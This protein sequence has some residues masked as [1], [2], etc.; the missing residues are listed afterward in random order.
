MIIQVADKIIAPFERL[1][2][3]LASVLRRRI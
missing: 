1:S 3:T 2:G